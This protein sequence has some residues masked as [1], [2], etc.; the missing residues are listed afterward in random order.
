MTCA[1]LRQ[2][3]PGSLDNPNRI[4]PIRLNTHK[5]TVFTPMRKGM[6]NSGIVVGSGEQPVEPEK[7]GNQHSHW[8]HSENKSFQT[9]LSR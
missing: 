5:I 1:S 6:A 7:C 2:P 3:S 4:A 8:G 9:E